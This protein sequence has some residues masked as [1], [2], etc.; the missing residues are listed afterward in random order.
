MQYAL[1]T[2]V[3]NPRCRLQTAQNGLLAVGAMFLF[4]EIGNDR[5]FAA[6]QPRA[7][8]AQTASV[9]T[10][11]PL[12]PSQAELVA[13]FNA[14]KATIVDLKTAS[15]LLKIKAQKEATLS[16]AGDKLKVTSTGT[17]P[18]L[19]LPPFAEGKQFILQVTIESPMDM[20]IEL[21]YLVQGQ[22]EHVGA[23]SFLCRMN[24]GKNVVY[25]K[26]DQPNLIDP[27]RLDPGMAPGD[28][29]IESIIA[30]VIK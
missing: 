20:G 2:G 8:P 9:S 4:G 5:L 24:K 27:I 19:L 25:F 1:T 17:D 7:T 10:S 30:R 13:A 12:S 29:V 26:L 18:Q 21:F 11:Q 28:Y 6:E 15:D 23:Q 3:R 14:S 16:A 22:T